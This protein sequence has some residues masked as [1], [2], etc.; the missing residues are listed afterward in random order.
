MLLFFS[1][2]QMPEN[3]LVIKSDPFSSD[4][5]KRSY[6]LGL[7]TKNTLLEKCYLGEMDEFYKK[8]SSSFKQK[9]NHFKYWNALG[10]CHVEGK[11]YL[12]STIYFEKAYSMAKK[13]SDKSNILNNLAYAYQSMTNDL[14][15]FSYYKE[16]Y[17]LNK[18][19]PIVNFNLVNIYLRG[20]YPEKAKTHLKKLRHLGKSDPEILHAYGS[21]EI[22]SKQYKQ[23]FQTYIKMDL[24]NL[25]NLEFYNHYLLASYLIRAKPKKIENIDYKDSKLK[26][27]HTAIKEQFEKK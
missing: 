27:K 25:K 17:R 6:K 20:G 11:K 8:M 9:V 4:S 5:V 23:A 3:K 10:I 21:L 22:L 2:S 19:N 24:E 16:A 14:R 12:E 13:R 18:N 7:P 26:E 15:A 1:C